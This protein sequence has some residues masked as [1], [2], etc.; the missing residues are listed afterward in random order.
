M[1][2]RFSSIK[3][4]ILAA[5]SMLAI[6]LLMLAYF[7][8]ATHETFTRTLG[9]AFAREEVL[10]LT[11][12][13]QR[14]VVDLQ[15]NVLIYK[16]A[17]SSGS[18]KN[19][20]YLYSHLKQSI[21]N[22]RAGNL[23]KI[24]GDSD[25]LNG[26][27]HHLSEY[28]ANFDIVVDYREQRSR[29]VEAH[30]AESFSALLALIE[31]AKLP[32]SLHST[33]NA[34]LIAANKNSLAYLAT[35]DFKFIELFKSE[36][37][38]TRD[39]LLEQ[40][41]N[42]ADAMRLSRAIE[43]YEKDFLRIVNLTRSYIYLINVVMAGSAQEIIYYADYLA[44]LAKESAAVEQQATNNEL[45]RWRTLIILLSGFGLAVAIFV[46]IYFFRLITKPIESITGVF[47]D[48]AAGKKVNEIPGRTREDE[49]GLLA[50]AANVFKAKNEQTQ[51]LLQEAENS[52]QIQQ[53]LNRELGDAKTRAEKALSVKSDFLANM[54]H[55]LRTP[56][57]SVIGYTVRLLKKAGE[58]NERQL[59][60][61]NAIERNGRHLL[62][63]INDILDLSKI[64][65][66]KLEMN[67]QMVDVYTLCLD[68]VEQMSPYS[69]EKHLLLIFPP[70]PTS[71]SIETDPVR[72]TQIL[73]NLLSNA[74]K[75]TEEGWVK[76]EM[77]VN[78]EGECVTITV[79]DSGI[80][81]EQEDMGRLFKRFEQLGP[82]TRFK[83]G[84]GTGLGLAIVAKLCRL[85]N[86]KVQVESEFGLGSC[87][88]VTLPFYQNMGLAGERA[89]LRA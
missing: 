45:M 42:S 22:L 31:E 57:N 77:A 11:A 4:Q 47:N 12:S 79:S 26:I 89:R 81:I 30:M 83:I 13:L 33:A 41:N 8:F 50:Q 24:Y 61:L 63:M 69:E 32:K 6:P 87:F 38:L 67:V 52:V 35:G 76:L 7:I 40:T 21:E 72:L 85:M 65:A 55:E 74:I 82:D 53:R 34:L 39:Q 51:K 18:V 37:K 54:S 1:G 23:L 36:T 64:E 43:D 49:I 48:L 27:S 84:N 15:R 75:Y 2:L 44:K 29:L 68:A 88:S 70:E 78:Q 59:S 9:N 80:G 3:F 58:F 60:A 86:A 14:D 28:K 56:L 19:V 5:F 71:C 20:E 73:I 62:A 66:D 17:V 25:A 16:N 10:S 46:P